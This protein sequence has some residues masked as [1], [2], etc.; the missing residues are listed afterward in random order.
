MFWA[1]PTSFAQSVPLSPSQTDCLIAFSRRRTQHRD[2]RHSNKSCCPPQ[3]A[4][5]AI[6]FV[7]RGNVFRPCSWPGGMM[8]CAVLEKVLS[9]HGGCLA[10]AAIQAVDLEFLVHLSMPKNLFNALNG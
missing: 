2:T 1:T 5:V 4:Q 8:E 9:H 7:P 3:R 10:K 6:D